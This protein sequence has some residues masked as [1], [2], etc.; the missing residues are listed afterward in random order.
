MINY[1]KAFQVRVRN[2]ECLF[3]DICKLIMIHLLKRKHKNTPIYTEYNP[4]NPNDSYPDIFMQIKNRRFIFEIQK[5]FSKK[6]L[7]EIT[8]KYDLPNYDLII[9]PLKD[10]PKEINQLKKELEK[11]VI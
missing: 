5:S 9:I 4:D 8:K 1:S 11:Y 6:W 10:L 7:N 3:H 2:T